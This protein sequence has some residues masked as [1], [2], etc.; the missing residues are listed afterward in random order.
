MLPWQ[1]VCQRVLEIFYRSIC[2]LIMKFQKFSKVKSELIFELI[3]SK[4]S[5]IDSMIIKA[6][7]SN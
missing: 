4:P 7:E 1:R 2:F 5:L 6:F 3:F